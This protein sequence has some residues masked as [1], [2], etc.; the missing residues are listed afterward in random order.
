M[1]GQAEKMSQLVTDVS[2]I[3]CFDDS[4]AERLCCW[5]NVWLVSFIKIYFRIW[6][7]LLSISME[8]HFIHSYFQLVSSLLKTADILQVL[9]R[10]SH[11]KDLYTQTRRV[12]WKT[13]VYIYP[14]S[15]FQLSW[16]RNKVAGGLLIDPTFTFFYIFFP[17]KG[18]C[19]GTLFF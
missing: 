11:L 8:K 3:I 15:T 6:E 2:M 19:L 10:K 13:T 7:L 1:Q 18:F 17:E 9:L 5:S 12:Q 14:T 4:S 16:V